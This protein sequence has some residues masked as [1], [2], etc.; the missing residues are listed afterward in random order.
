MEES[1]TRLV[2]VITV[3]AAAHPCVE[4]VHGNNRVRRGT[5]FML[6]FRL[7]AEKEAA[8]TILRSASFSVI[9][10]CGWLCREIFLVVEKNNILTRMLLSL[11]STN[12]LIPVLPLL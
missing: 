1:E 11:C 12:L 9:C 7:H 10:I 6:F 5:L 3:C 2:N 4:L 8:S